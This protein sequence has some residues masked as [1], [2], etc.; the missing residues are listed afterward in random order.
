MSYLVTSNIDM[1]K[2]LI[3]FLTI[4][5]FGCRGEETTS[6]KLIIINKSGVTVKIAPSLTLTDT[7]VL[8]NNQIYEYRHGLE[9]GITPGIELAYFADGN[10]VL[11]RFDNKFPVIHYRDTF[12]HADKSYNITSTR[13]FYN[14]LSYSKEI[15]DNNKY[16][17]FVTLTYTFTIEDY[18]FAK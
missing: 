7:L 6:S 14:P 10:P 2:Y 8:V 15:K 12:T 16:S 18:Q 17:R 9:R 3:Y 11:V 4:I 5:L 1:L 13:C